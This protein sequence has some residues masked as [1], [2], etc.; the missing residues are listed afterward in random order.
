M[1]SHLTPDVRGAVNILV[2]IGRMARPRGIAEEV[3]FP[4]RGG[5]AT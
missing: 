1:T 5:R 4:A 3:A 2:P